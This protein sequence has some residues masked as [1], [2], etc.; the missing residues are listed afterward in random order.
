ML[1][2][3]LAITWIAGAFT[4]A[5]ACLSTAPARAQEG[6]WCAYAGGWNAYENCGYYTLQQC[7]AATRGVGG[8]CK[9]NPYARF[10]APYGY[11]DPP[12]PRRRVRRY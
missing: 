10:E 11:D 12:P 3:K 6:A 4:I 2:P 8:A 5:A 9:P 1:M 7:V